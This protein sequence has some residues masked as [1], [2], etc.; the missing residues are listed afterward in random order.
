M[1]LLLLLLPNFP[2]PLAK[3]LMD[4][5]TLINLKCTLWKICWHRIKQRL[6]AEQ[7][8]QPSINLKM[9]PKK[10]EKAKRYYVCY[11]MRASRGYEI[12]GMES[13][14]DSS[15]LYLPVLMSLSGFLGH[16]QNAFLLS[17]APF[18]SLRRRLLF[19]KQNGSISC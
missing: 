4:Q 15:R 12:I 16:L 1:V 8:L 14:G 5:H 17:A 10:M 6:F 18:S 3:L 19:C 7:Q 2:T 9:V 13:S 11:V